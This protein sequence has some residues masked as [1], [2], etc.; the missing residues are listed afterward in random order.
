MLRFS[1]VGRTRREVL[2]VGA[3]TAF[4]LGLPDVLR[5]RELAQASP[6]Q[7]EINVILLWQMGAASQIDLYDLKPH[8]P[9][10]IRGPYNPI[11]TNVGGV[12]LGDLLP[13]LSRCADKFSLVRSITSPE[14]DHERAQYF[15]LSGWPYS[16]N[17]PQVIPP[18]FGALLAY[19]RPMPKD[20]PSHVQLGDLL[21]EAP[22]SAA[23]GVL[24]QQFNPMVVS[25]Q[26]RV[27]GLDVPVGSPLSRVRGRQDLLSNLDRMQKTFENGKRSLSAYNK[28]VEKAF[29][30]V[31]SAKAKRAFDLSEES[32][33]TRAL[34]GRNTIGDRVLTARRLIEA[35]VRFVTAVIRSEDGGWDNH[36]GIF[37]KLPKIV[38]PYDQ[39]NAALLTDL[40]QR[41]LRENTLV[42][43]MGE[44]GRTPKLSNL[45][46][47]QGPGIGRDHWGKCFSLLIG[48]GGVRTGELFGG[49]D[50]YAAFPRD[51]AWKVTDLAATIYHL[52][53]V[54]PH[55]EFYPPDMRLLFP[56]FEGRVI[57]EWLV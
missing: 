37:Q 50:K 27:E 22:G 23:G 42:I 20:V 7:R 26:E 10:T 53:G 21:K 25:A 36:S 31:T 19:Q 30:M 46:S 3:L 54:D 16:Q 2:R 18:S 32:D 35:G 49:S 12:E 13:N 15:V 8:A 57:E 55:A 41:G 11:K 29:A 38:P 39:A 47:E 9:D 14:E 4:G 56:K 24:G 33:G 45:K 40:D 5:R 48:G 34:Y 28:H 1:E 52:L 43:T 17:I 44:F 51:V 6:P